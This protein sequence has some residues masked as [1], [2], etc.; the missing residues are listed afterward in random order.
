MSGRETHQ[1]AVTRVGQW[2]DLTDEQRREFVDS[3][4]H[5]GLEEAS[6]WEECGSHPSRQRDRGRAPA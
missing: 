4:D 2:L 1:K 6:T 5:I 3:V